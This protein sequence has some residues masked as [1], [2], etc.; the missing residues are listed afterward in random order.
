MPFERWIAA[1]AHSLA[2]RHWRVHYDTPLPLLTRFRC[3]IG[4]VKHASRGGVLELNSPVLRVYEVHRLL[5]FSLSMSDSSPLTRQQLYDKIRAS[6][7]DAY[8]LDEMKRLGFWPDQQ[9]MPS[10]PE[11]FIQKEGELTRELQELAKQQRKFGDREQMLKEI[12][13]ERMAASRQ[14]QQ[15]T[16]ERK[17]QERQE[18]AQQWEAFRAKEIIYLGEG[19][20]AGLQSEEED[21]ET[22]GR[23][24]L[25]SFPDVAA[26]SEAMEITVGAL[27]FLS[28]HRKVSKVSHYKR[29][30]IRKKRGGKRLISAPM[31]RLKKAQHWILQNILN[32]VTLHSAAHGFVTQRSIVT[33]ATPHLKAELVVNIDLKDFFPTIQYRRVKGIFRA[34]GYSEKIATVLGLLCTE[35]EVDQIALDGRNYFVAKGERVLPQGAPT[36]PALT[37][38]LCRKLDARLQGLAQ[39]YG[40]T[41]TRYADDMT[42]S[43]SGEARQHLTQ[44]LA[45]VRRII[46]DEG[47]VLHPD[48]LRIMR[49]GA[50]RE[51]TGV[52]VNEQL[53]INRKRIKKFKALLFQIEKDGIEGKHWDGSDHLLSSV[54]GYAHYIHSVN[55]KV[56]ADLVRRTE[57]ILK[58]HDFEHTI[59]HPAKQ[60]TMTDPPPEKPT[61]TFQEDKQEDKPWWK[62][63]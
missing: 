44:L 34:L 19:V 17:Q 39:K 49:K 1:L 61:S 18:K 7:K 42:F 41:Y 30:Y 36:S 50:R 52:V 40:F 45:N 8:I 22:L 57:A 58:K 12:R 31:P 26:L 3:H 10:P 55:P 16:K 27:R 33:N 51:V 46:K 38:I 43:T 11:Q 29:F 5:L 60:Q 15:E 14:K 25:P 35:S 23:Y 48:K 9:D 56:G 2:T 20:S 6:S 47:L 13:R 63:W 53:T 4:D 28:Y 59:Q 37:N 21:A 24:G 62:F 32:K 54:R